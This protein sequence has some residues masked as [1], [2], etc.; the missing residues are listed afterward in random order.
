MMLQ[1]NLLERSL[2]VDAFSNNAVDEYVLE[3]WGYLQMAPKIHLMKH[4]KRPFLNQEGLEVPLHKYE[5]Y[6]E[7]DVI[8]LSVFG[9]LREYLQI[10]TPASENDGESVE[11]IEGV[12]DEVF[13]FSWS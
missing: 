8:P 5:G 6:F 2:T 3:V 9:M 1:L 13:S 10:K 4:H 12:D 7:K 11:D